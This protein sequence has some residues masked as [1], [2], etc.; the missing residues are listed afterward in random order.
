MRTLTVARKDF[1]D[2]RRT[3]TLWLVVGLLTFLG[4]LMAYVFP[5]N[6]SSISATE[7]FQQALLGITVVVSIILPIVVLIATYL[8]IAGER[9]S[10]SI[11]FMLSLPNS[12]FSVFAGKVLSRSGIVLGAVTLMLLIVAGILT[13][14]LGA[15]P[16]AFVAGTTAIV[17][18]YSLSFVSVAI[19]MSSSLATRSRAIAGAVGSYF[20]LVVFYVFPI[21]SV[22][23]VV[24]W[25][26]HDLLGMATNQDLYDFVEFTSPFMA[27]RKSLN[28]VLP[29]DLENGFTRPFRATRVEEVSGV[30]SYQ[31]AL[32]AVDLPVYLTDG[33]ALVIFAFW[34][35]V[36][37]AIGYWR[38]ERAELG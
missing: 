17:G 1:K 12:R 9:E 2:A 27:F 15:F 37:L 35:T 31:E 29:S 33:F 7:A 10:G 16:V 32:Q 5:N 4:A 20:V 14:T 38:F 21:A 18:L 36:P 8:A 11:K 25:L 13:V 26:H 24:R 6:N 22:T 19:A 30:S 3:K 23:D 34:I 28:L